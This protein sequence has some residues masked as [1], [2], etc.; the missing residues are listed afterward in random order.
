[1]SRLS[2]IGPTPAL[3]ESIRNALH[4]NTVRKDEPQ[5]AFV[6]DSSLREIWRSPRLQ[7]FFH[8]RDWC[9]TEALKTIY[10]KFLRILS[11][12]V[13]IRWQD[14]HLF[15]KIFLDPRASNGE[16]VRADGCLPF[17][18]LDQLK[19][20][21]NGELR[22]RMYTYQHVF[23]PVQIHLGQTGHYKA[24]RRLPFESMKQLRPEFSAVVFRV[25]VAECHL[26]SD[27]RRTCNA[28]VCASSI[29]LQLI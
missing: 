10:D 13:Y 18:H 27:G 29:H 20:L 11:I 12:L 7:H 3:Q 24:P 17:A 23:C 26:L 21:Q 25:L 22:Q 8:R 5:S 9:T 19:F 14:W 28:Q 6:P 15:R 4:E 16:H 2:S 1:M